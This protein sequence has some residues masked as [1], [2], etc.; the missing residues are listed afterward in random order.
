MAPTSRMM[1]ISLRRANMPIRNVFAINATA[2]ASM[3]AAID[4]I[5]I[6]S[7]RVMATSL[8]SRSR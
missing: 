7:T 4:R 2:D 8:D 5:P 6:E 3:I 1:P